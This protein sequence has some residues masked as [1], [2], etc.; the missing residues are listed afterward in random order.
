[1]VE[2]LQT[3]VMPCTTS[4]NLNIISSNLF[5]P[6]LPVDQLNTLPSSGDFCRLQIKTMHTLDC[7]ATDLNPN[8]LTL[9][10]FFF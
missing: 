5:Q 10:F 9:D 1:M 2:N 6:S 4:E 8:C 7:F 3:K